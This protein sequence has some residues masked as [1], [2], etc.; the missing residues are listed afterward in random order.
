VGTS[1]YRY[2]P[3]RDED[4]DPEDRTT[5]SLRQTR[6]PATAAFAFARWLRSSY[7][8]P[9]APLGTI[10]LLLSPSA[11]ERE[12]IRGLAEVADAVR[13][14]TRD[15][16]AEAVDAWFADCATNRDHVAILYASGHGIQISKDEGGIV[17]LEDFARRPTAKLEHTL[18]VQ[19]VRAGMAGEQMA[20]TQLYFVDACRVRPGELVD[21]RDLQDGVGID[22]P[23]EGAADCSAVFFGAAPSTEA[24]GKPGRGTFFGRALLDCLR[25]YAAN[26]YLVENRWVITTTSLIRALPARLHELTE[27]FGAV[28]HPT[29]GGQIPD[30][31]IHTL[32][33]P[34]PAELTLTLS[35]PEAAG[36]ARAR[37]LDRNSVEVF[38]GR[39][40]D[41]AIVAKVQAGIYTLDVAIDPPTPPYSNRL[42]P[43]AALS[44]SS[45]EI[46]RVT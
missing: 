31:V 11:F 25:G 26:D 44:P 40:F 20:Q 4:P 7:R 39:R 45:Q 12:R 37:L 9:S 22:R 38:S 35:P 43:V 30:V 42:L 27:P 16:V 21:A 3:E 32:S 17:L 46:V 36:C 15:E 2:L 10:R 34:P 13:S 18:N 6:T 14:A 23:Y 33:K 28:Q 29:P 1:R 41:P 24:L 8:N 5:F 19:R